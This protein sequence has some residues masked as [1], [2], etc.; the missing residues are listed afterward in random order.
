MEMG[1]LL[2][3]VAL[4]L[5]AW[6]VLATQTADVTFTPQVGFGGAS[7][8]NGTLKLLFGK[9]RPYHVESQG[10]VQGRALKQADPVHS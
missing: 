4:A 6:L 3:T 5:P 7:E 8:G 10:Y 1:I 9:Q 2:L